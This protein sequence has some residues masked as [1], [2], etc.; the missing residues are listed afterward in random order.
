[1]HSFDE[2]KEIRMFKDTH[3]TK[4]LRAYSLSPDP[5]DVL[6]PVK[7]IYMPSMQKPYKIIEESIEINSFV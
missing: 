4:K 3:Y 6:E 7:E 2:Y 5:P 1:M